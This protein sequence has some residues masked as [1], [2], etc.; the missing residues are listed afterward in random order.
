[1]AIQAVRV[2]KSSFKEWKLHGPVD[3]ALKTSC[4]ADAVKAIPL[5]LDDVHGAPVDVELWVNIEEGD[6]GEDEPNP[7]GMMILQNME[8]SKQG[9]TPAEALLAGYELPELPVIKGVAVL[10]GAGGSD[11]P[12]GNFRCVIASLVGMHSAVEE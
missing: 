4:Q 3:Q 8:C 12:M 9:I 2:S 6:P 10:T 5:H 1:M 11:F 7:H